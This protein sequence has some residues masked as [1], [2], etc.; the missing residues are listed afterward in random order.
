MLSA[1]VVRVIA[2]E[3]GRGGDEFDREATVASRLAALGASVR[4]RLTPSLTHVVV[5]GDD[6][7]ALSALYDRIRAVRGRGAALA[8]VVRDASEA[9]SR[10]LARRPELPARFAW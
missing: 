8:G 6:S 10:R 4:T 1:C 3:P 7:A 2:T 5:L 9:R